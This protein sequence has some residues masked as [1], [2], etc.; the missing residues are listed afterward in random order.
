MDAERVFVK[1]MNDLDNDTVAEKKVW[2]ILEKEGYGTDDDYLEFCRYLISLG[3]TIR[4]EEKR[5]ES[6]KLDARSQYFNSLQY[7]PTMTPEEE[8]ELVDKMRFGRTPEE[9][10]AAFDE[11]VRRYQKFVV[12]IAKNYSQSADLMDL[13]EYGNEGLMTAIKKYDPSY[14]ARIGTFA[15]EY[16]RRAISRGCFREQSIP[17][18]RYLTDQMPRIKAYFSDYADQYGCSP[19]PEELMEFLHLNDITIAQGLIRYFCPRV[20]LDAA[21][22]DHGSLV[23]DLVPDENTDLEEEAMRCATAAQIWRLIDKY[24]SKK[25]RTILRRK[26]GAEYDGQSRCNRAIAEEY[27]YKTGETIRIII[28]NG[29]QKVL[30]SPEGKTIL[31]AS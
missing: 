30:T 11:L 25:E 10:K 17:L 24:C 3:I 18:P 12:S 1:H 5:R 6:E 4:H 8:R 7:C 21:V 29:L 23:S 19:T 20:Y 28:K 31:A 2:S 9:Q 13:I 22:G 15:R 14:G 26:Y 27:G 16:I